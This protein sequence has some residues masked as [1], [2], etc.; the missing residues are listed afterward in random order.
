MDD[1]FLQSRLADLAG[2]SD[3]RDIYTF[4][5]F[6]SPSEAA[7]VCAAAGRVPFRFWGGMEGCERCV[8]RFGDEERIGYEVPF[9]I[10]ILQVTP[11]NEK[12]AD[13]LTHRDFLGALM[14]LGIER[15][16]IGDILIRDNTAWICALDTVA[17]LI[18]DELTSVKRTTVSCLPV[19]QVPEEAAIRLEP[20]SLNIP[21]L[22]LDA[23]IG[24]LYHLPRGKAKELFAGKLVSINGIVCTNESRQPKEGDV[25]SVRGHGRFRFT[26]LSGQT[27]K[28]RVVA[29]VEV[30]V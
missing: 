20:Q 21:S 18:R 3:R 24:R 19:E 26:G 16:T 27:K 23:L 8:A 17:P 14:H 12:F 4:S 10:S 25:I 5:D 6:L 11:L 13:D 2:Q 28:G 9:P 22:R 30:Y 1:K 7:L 15:S 29:D